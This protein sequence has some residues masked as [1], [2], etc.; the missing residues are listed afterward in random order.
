MEKILVVDFNG[1]SPVY[2]HYFSEGLITPDRK[3][4]VLGVKKSKFLDVFSDH[5]VYRGI[6][7]KFKSLGYIVNWLWLLMN[8]NKYDVIII[9]W[10]Q[11]IRYSRFEVY[12]IQFLQSRNNLFYVAHNL[13]PHRHSS[14]K[15]RRNFDHLYRVTNKIAVHT[16]Q[17]QNKILDITGPRKIY[18]AYHGLFFHDSKLDSNL[19]KKN[20]CIM[21][22]YIAKYKGIEDAIEVVKLLREQGYI[23]DLQII[24]AG[25]KSYIN[26]LKKKITSYNL[27]HQIKII[28]AE[29]SSTKLVSI[30]QKVSMVWLP[31]KKISQS[32]VSY[33][34]IGLKKP[35]VAYD[36]GN[37]K[38]EF[39][40]LGV[41]EIAEPGDI[42]DFSDRVKKVMN[43]SSFYKENIVKAYENFSWKRNES[44]LN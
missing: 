11:L 6:K 20:S 27:D 13:Y 15:V 23:I 5:M 33:S 31:Y 3:V 14:E 41:A 1:T 30:I 32:G 22:G 37:F 44:L 10:L 24:G 17:L 19:F 8:S 21:I 9:Q 7:C 43:N 35:F 28:G 38:S 2:T 25:P 39:G 42:S 12:L 40:V 18:R 16:T 4:E 36:V 26:D 34:S 29:I